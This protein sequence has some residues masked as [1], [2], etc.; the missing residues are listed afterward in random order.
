MG[1]SPSLP[2]VSSLKHIYL[3]T[4]LE[5]RKWSDKEPRCG[6]PREVLPGCSTPGWYL[7]DI[8]LSQ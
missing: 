3:S 6:W 8:G 4:I 2:G 1:E 7:L 5:Y